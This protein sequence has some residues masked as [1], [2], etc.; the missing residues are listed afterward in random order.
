MK[1][2][3][4]P[5]RR[6]K[7]ERKLVYESQKHIQQIGERVRHLEEALNQKADE[8]YFWDLERQLRELRDEHEQVVRHVEKLEDQVSDLEGRIDDLEADIP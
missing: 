8:W 3:L 2:R 6:P 7:E 4:H 5:S 1:A